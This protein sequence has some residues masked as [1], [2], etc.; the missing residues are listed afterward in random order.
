MRLHYIVK[1]LCKIIRI[2]PNLCRLNEKLFY[3][4]N[5]NRFSVFSESYGGNKSQGLHMIGKLPR[6]DSTEQT[7]KY[8]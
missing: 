1:I 4:T 3:W 5:N 2:I 6:N 8:S 7:I